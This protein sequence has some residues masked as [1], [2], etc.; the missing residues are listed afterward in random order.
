MPARI[1]H[2]GEQMLYWECHSATYSEGGLSPSETGSGNPSIFSKARLSDVWNE[3]QQGSFSD[4]L[5]RWYACLDEYSNRNLTYSSDKL[6]AVAGLAKSMHDR[7]P[8][9]D[10][11]YAGIWKADFVRGLL[12]RARKLGCLSQPPSYRAPSWSWAALE[13]EIKHDW[14][15]LKY[16]DPTWWPTIE[17]ISVRCKGRSVYGE[18]ESAAVRLKAPMRP[19]VYLGTPPSK[20]RN[21]IG[22]FD[23]P[24]QLADDPTQQWYD[25][26]HFDPDSWDPVGPPL[27]KAYFDGPVEER[28]V[29]PFALMCLGKFSAFIKPEDW[30]EERDWDCNFWALILEEVDTDSDSGMLKRV[31]IASITDRTAFTGW[32]TLEKTIV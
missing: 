6:P 25:L 22:P 14:Y 19:A 11:Y 32:G 8:Q 21:I 15:N 4:E 29:R 3:E 27:C 9:L 20:G 28:K 1:V 23:L 10:I 2:F 30:W 13:G 17:G 26:W 31:G 24:V 18:I 12:W 16:F 7:T 5:E